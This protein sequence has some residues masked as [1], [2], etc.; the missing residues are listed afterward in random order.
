MYL[1]DRLL[2]ALGERPFE[3]A[4]MASYFDRRLDVDASRTRQRLG[5]VPRERLSIRRRLPFMIENLKCEPLEW[6]RRNHMAMRAVMT[7]ANLKIH[8]L[9]EKHEAAICDT[10]AE[11][12][13][14]QE[15][16]VLF[17]TYQGLTHEEREWN[18]RVAVRHLLDSV[19]TRD[20]SI[21]GN[22]CRDLGELRF[23][24]GFDPAEVREALR[25]FRDVCLGFL[26]GDENAAGLTTD[27]ENHV[28][29]TMLYGCDQIEDAFDHLTEPEKQKNARKPEKTLRA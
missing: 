1:R 10:M 11:L 4:W 2:G 28:F 19:R 6:H 17:P 8:Q 27:I 7:S 12:M 14:N 15:G 26:H 29:M 18:Y 3:R 5:W 23:A 21:Y 25:T 9:L 16:R 20:K 22:F 24:Q 13:T